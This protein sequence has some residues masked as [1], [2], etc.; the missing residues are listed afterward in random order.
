MPSSARIVIVI[1][2]HWLKSGVRLVATS[3]QVIVFSLAFVVTLQF[4]RGG[5]VPLPDRLPSF[6]PLW[7]EAA[8]VPQRFLSMAPGSWD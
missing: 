7:F 8:E 2:D 5:D 6:A 4:A 1:D 3:K